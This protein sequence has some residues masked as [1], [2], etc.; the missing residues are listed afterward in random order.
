[1]LSACLPAEG[2]GSGNLIGA[3][4]EAAFMLGMER[5]S[6]GTQSSTWKEGAHTASGGVGV[7]LAGAYAPL[8][9]NANSVPWPTNMIVFD[10]HRWVG[11]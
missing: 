7:V 4:A 8:L 5:N 1:M 11:G 10:S 9:V 2:G 6:G 3:V